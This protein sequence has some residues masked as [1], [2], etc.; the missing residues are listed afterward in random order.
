MA[1]IPKGSTGMDLLT[2]MCRECNNWFNK[3]NY[4][5]DFSDVEDPANFDPNTGR[6]EGIP[7]TFYR[8][9]E[10][11][12]EYVQDDNNKRT[13]IQ[14]EEWG[15]SI[16]YSLDLEMTQWNKAF[17]GELDRYRRAKFI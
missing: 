9:W 2:E 6:P 15:Q 11:I 1:L 7:S 13:A 12:D 8:L 17:K 16:G 4:E 3:G 5:R 10:Q 14:S